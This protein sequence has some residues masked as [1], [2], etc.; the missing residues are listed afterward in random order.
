MS[1]TIETVLLNAIDDTINEN[2]FS[3]ESLKDTQQLTYIGK[4]EWAYKK[5]LI[6]TLNGNDYSIKEWFQG[7]ALNNLPMWDS[8]I[9]ELGLNSDT[10]WDD[11][12]KTL[13]KVISE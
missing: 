13:I 3:N 4:F 6:E 11:L 2:D 5:Y 8:E 1:K 10:Y 9:E 12:A 7:L